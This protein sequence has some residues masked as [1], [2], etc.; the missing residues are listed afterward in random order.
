MD[1]SDL[2]GPINELAKQVALFSI[3]V[4]LLGFGVGFVLK[5]LRIPKVLF[6]PLLGLSV[7]YIAY[8][9]FIILIG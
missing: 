7:L 2:N 9:T 3:I 1:F 6:E 5:I 4:I 8:K